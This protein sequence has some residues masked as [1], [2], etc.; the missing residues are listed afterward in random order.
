MPLTTV[1]GEGMGADKGPPADFCSGAEGPLGV[2]QV[3]RPRTVAPTALQSQTS[4]RRGTGAAD[5]ARGALWEGVQA[6]SGHARPRG[7]RPP[8]SPGPCT[9]AFRR[10]SS[11]P[12]RP[13]CSLTADPPVRRAAL[14]QAAGCKDW[15]RFTV[16]VATTALRTRGPCGARRFVNV[17]ETAVRKYIPIAGDPHVQSSRCSGSQDIHGWTPAPIP[18]S[19]VGHPAPR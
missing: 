10:R 5:R 16:P 11:G 6:R 12:W 4:R 8:C 14:R 1:W 15:S 2:P 13:P 18:Q 19:A 3:G 17:L 9:P 7:R